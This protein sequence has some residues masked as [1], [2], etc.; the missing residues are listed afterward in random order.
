MPQHKIRDI[1]LEI[2][3]IY[4]TRRRFIKSNETFSQV[5][6]LF[7]AIIFGECTQFI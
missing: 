6:L 1:H 4:M 3:L 5:F 7:F 2:I